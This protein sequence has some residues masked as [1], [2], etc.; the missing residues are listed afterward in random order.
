MGSPRELERRIPLPSTKPP[1]GWIDQHRL[2]VAVARG[3]GPPLIVATQVGNHPATGRASFLAY[4]GDG[5][6]PLVISELEGPMPERGWELRTSGLWADHICETP[7]EHW[8]YG[9]EAFALAVDEP[10]ELLGRGFGD[11]VPL[12]WELDFEASEEPDLHGAPPPQVAIGNVSPAVEPS[13]EERPA[14]TFDAGGAAASGWYRQL[15]VVS[16]ILLDASGETEIEG[17]AIRSHRWGSARFGPDGL[18]ADGG[19]GGDEAPSTTGFG[20]DVALPG[21]D[22]VWWITRTP[23]GVRTLTDY[24]L[25]P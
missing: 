25:E 19:S 20:V 5:S 8:S 7:F 15:G 17:R 22:E 2:L 11:R 9:L 16:G 14:P 18:L 4:V 3:D 12:G 23:A 24:D 10:R 21:I 1:A 6:L 13:G